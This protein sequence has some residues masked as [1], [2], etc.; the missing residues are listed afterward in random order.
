MQPRSMALPP[1]TIG[2]EAPAGHPDRRPLVEALGGVDLLCLL[3]NPVLADLRLHHLSARG[4]PG[5]SE[6]AVVLGPLLE[7]GW[8]ATDKGGQLLG[9]FLSDGSP[10][11]VHRLMEIVLAWARRLSLERLAELGGHRR[12]SG[13][14][15]DLMRR[16]DGLPGVIERRRSGS[17]ELPAELT[18]GEEVEFRIR[19]GGREEWWAYLLDLGFAADVCRLHPEPGPGQPVAPGGT[20]CVE[21]LRIEF[22]AGFPFGSPEDPKAW[23]DGTAVLFTSMMPVD[24]DPLFLAA[25]AADDRSPLGRILEAVLAGARSPSAHD[26]ADPSWAAATPLHMFVRRLGRRR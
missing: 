24:L 25:G 8:V 26:V 11:C 20:V 15:L 23:G 22:P 9:P 17:R 2:L 3:D 16:V 5:Y 7:P 18:V 6:P 1:I 19:N 10:G 13:A 4:R 14:G 12:D 21:S